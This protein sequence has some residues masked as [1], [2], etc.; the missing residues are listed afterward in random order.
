MSENDRITALRRPPSGLAGRLRELADCVDRGEVLEFVAC[1]DL[2]GDF[3]FIRG[4]SK[5]NAIAMASMLHDEALD[6]MRLPG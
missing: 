5:L 2:N 3:H 6:Q 4:A 1:H